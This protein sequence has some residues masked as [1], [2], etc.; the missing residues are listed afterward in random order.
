M[1]ILPFVPLIKEIFDRVIPN[2]TAQAEA[3]NTLD[4]MALSGELKTQ[5]AQL[6]IN[7]EEAKHPTIFVAGWRPYIGWV[8]GT[9]LFYQ[10]VLVYIIP[11]TAGAPEI[12][13]EPILIVLSSLLGLNKILRT[14]EKI[15]GVARS[16]FGGKPDERD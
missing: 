4:E 1:N 15:K 6:A 2:K 5:L 13:V 8:C 11:T 10:T 7:L 3:K 9:A 14:V 16:N 12:D